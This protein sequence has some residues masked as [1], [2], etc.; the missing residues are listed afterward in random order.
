MLNVPEYSGRVRDKGFGVTPTSLGIKK[1]GKDHSNKEVMEELEKL[2][3][4][5]YELEKDKE[6]HKAAGQ[7]SRFK[8]T[9]EKNSINCDFQ[10]KFLEVIY[11][12]MKLNLC[13]LFNRNIYRHTHINNVIFIIGLGN[14]ILVAIFVVTDLSHSWQGKSA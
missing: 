13:N 11:I 8:D 5:I 9:S 14:F 2:K 10:T 6:R 1:K 7:G 3:A 12:I 4:K